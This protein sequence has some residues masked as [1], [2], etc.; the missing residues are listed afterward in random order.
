[1][2]TWVFITRIQQEWDT[3]ERPLEIT[4]ITKEARMSSYMEAIPRQRP[5][6][7]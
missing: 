7:I 3:L 6:P 5:P 4:G 2:I 1:M